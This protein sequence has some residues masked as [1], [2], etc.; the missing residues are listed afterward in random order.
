MFL[1]G[2][3]GGGLPAGWGSAGSLV[4]GRAPA[5]V[6]T[7]QGPSGR[8]RVTEAEYLSCL[9]I[10]KPPTPPLVRMGRLGPRQ[11]A[12]LTCL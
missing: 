8:G 5:Q 11:A 3:G 2:S 1:Q 12:E 4:E 7:V 9:D 6:L 10:W